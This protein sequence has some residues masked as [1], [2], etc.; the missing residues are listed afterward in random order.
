[1]K[2]YHVEEFIGI[3][4]YVSKT[5]GIGGRIREKIEDFIV[6]EITPEREI[7]RAGRNYGANVERHSRYLIFLLEKH[8]WDTF[9][10]IEALARRLN[11]SP[12]NFS[13]AGIKDKKAITIQR[14]SVWKVKPEDLLNI[15][16]NDLYV[17]GCWYSDNKVNI[18][19][20]WGNHFRIIIRKISLDRDEIQHRVRGVLSEI[21]K[22]GGAPNF[23]GY[24]RFGTKR[25]INHIIGK[26]I[27]K[28]QFKD[29]VIKF[30]TEISPYEDEMTKEARSYLREN[31][32]FEEAA[33]KFP[34]YLWYEKRMLKFLS[35]HPRSYI[36]ALRLIP[37]QLRIMFTHSYTSYLFNRFVSYRIKIK[38]LSEVF[39]GDIVLKI[40][41]NG[42]PSD[43]IY[44][45]SSSNIKEIHE[46]V[47]K[48]K[49]AVALPLIGYRIKIP[50]GETGEIIKKILEEEGVKLE[51]FRVKSM[52][53]LSVKGTYR[54]VILKIKDFEV[55]EPT[56]DELNPSTLK[57]LMCFSI[58]KGGYATIVLREF[59]KPRDPILSGF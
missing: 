25:P 10:A 41:K 21:E 31:M 15:R 39:Q 37:K 46:E 32:N 7:L 57:V 49:A 33:K 36:S 22:M 29:A 16:I 34:N 18:G 24:Q 3:S 12:E 4:G 17:R 40:N 30:L 47:E 42:L 1:M 50:S 11:V 43:E 9:R 20:L 5:E 59:M 58:P 8:N 28:G 23:F 35:K 53:E 52:P 51:D 48:G 26:Y 44:E 55:M 38:A 2:I 6:E 13:I 14:V 56:E 27:V 54:P 45:V 19:D